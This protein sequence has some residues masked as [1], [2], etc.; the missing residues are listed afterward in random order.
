[1]V[2]TVKKP[3]INLQNKEAFDAFSD[4]VD[5]KISDLLVTYLTTGKQ[6]KLRWGD[7]QLFSHKGNSYLLDQGNIL[8]ICDFDQYNVFSDY[9]DFEGC[10]DRALNPVENSPAIIIQ[11]SKRA[12]GVTPGLKHIALINADSDNGSLIQFGES[13]LPMVSFLC[14]MQMMQTEDF[15]DLT[16]AITHGNLI[17]LDFYTEQQIKCAKSEIAQIN[18]LRKRTSPRGINYD[19]KPPKLGFNIIKVNNSWAWH[20]TGAILLHNKELNKYYIFGQDEG[21]YFGCELPA[22]CSSVEEAYRMLVP[23]GLRNRTDWKRQGEWFAVPVADKDIPDFPDCVLMGDTN[24]RIGNT[25]IYLPILTTDDNR[26]YLETYEN[27][28]VAKN[29]NVY[30][31]NVVLVHE[32]HESLDLKGWHT[33]VR[34]TAIRSVSQEGVD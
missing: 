16:T 14:V 26:H 34:N 19:L 32:E 2:A 13:G 24:H 5:T 10:I 28:R 12:K 17:L 30:V 33:F 23:E 29:G 25:H 6:S 21:T 7:I 27:I 1:M 4:S 3:V 9:M 22:K 11:C 31:E 15:E 18:R 20:S 8:Y